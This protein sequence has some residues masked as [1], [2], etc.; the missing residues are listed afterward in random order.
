MAPSPAPV[1]DLKTRLL[2]NALTCDRKT[3]YRP[4]RTKTGRAEQDYARSLL[5]IARHTGEIISAYKPFDM[6]FLKELMG[7]LGAYGEALK[8]WAAQTAS[9]MLQEVNRRDIDSWRSLG[10]TISLQLRHDLESTPVGATMRELLQGQV[11]LISSLPIEAAERVHRLTLEGLGDS[12]R[13]QDIVEAIRNSGTVT[14]SRA[15]MIAR[16]ETSRTA[17]EL[18]RVRAQ[19]AGSEDFIWHTSEDADV[20][21]DHKE[22]DGK[23][24]KWTEPPIADKRTGARALPGAIYNCRCYAEARLPR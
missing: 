2:P 17:T 3:R 12:S 14:E 1:L 22:L 7:L 16:T 23:V 5:F 4:R 15:T 18:N 20:R 6:K 13:Y 19:G 10:E 8:P 24:F 9:R 11:Q 21:P